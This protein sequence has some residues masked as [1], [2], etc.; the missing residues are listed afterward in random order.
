VQEH[1]IERLDGLLSAHD[2]AFIKWDMNRSVSEPG[3]P[4]APRD[5]RELWVRYV[6]GLYRVWGELRARHPAVIWQSCAGGGGRADL[7]ILRF[8]DQI[9]TS[10]NTL[11]TSRLEIQHG[12]SQ[13][14]P[15]I[16]MEA[17]VTDMGPA[18][19]VGYLPLSFRFHVSMCGSLGIGANLLEWGEAERAEAAGWV[20]LYKEIRPIVQLGDQYRLRSP[21]DGPL[22]AVQYV[23]KDR[24]EAV[25]FAFRTHEA[26]LV[27]HPPIRL[28]G[29][30]PEA[31]YAVE[32][33]EGVRSGAAWMRLGID[34]A[35]SDFQSTVR[36]IR[37]IET[38]TSQG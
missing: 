21:L 37:Q 14:F 31:R 7:G 26:R 34:L 25:L 5:Q 10:D 30:D 27:A 32:G 16:T 23:G 38:A 15:A 20:A 1:L 24:R 9:W 29:L 13:L 6:H 12:F 3:W 17:W 18:Y 8:A 36:R 33:V 4:G 2:I 28:L 11:P 19:G 22:S 35:L